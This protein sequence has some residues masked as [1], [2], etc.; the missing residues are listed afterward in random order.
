M[1]R[2]SQKRGKIRDRGVHTFTPPGTTG[3][4]NDWVLVLDDAAKQYGAPGKV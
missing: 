2:S 4:T 1:I 3:A